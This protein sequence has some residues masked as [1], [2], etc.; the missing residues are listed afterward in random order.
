DGAPYSGGVLHAGTHTL[1]VTFTPTDNA[2][3][4]P[5]AST[6]MLVVDQA[7]QILTIAAV[8]KQV[9]GVAPFTVAVTGGASGRPVVVTPTPVSPCTA[10]SVS[11]GFVTITVTGAGTCVLTATQDGTADYSDAVPRQL[12]FVVD[13]RQASVTLAAIPTHTYGDAP[14]SVNA[15][16]TGSTAP[17][18]LTA[19][20][21]SVCNLSGTTV[22]LTGPGTCTVTADQA[23]DANYY[24][25]PTVKISFAVTCGV[26]VLTDLTKPVRSGAT[27]PIQLQLVGS[28]GGNLWSSSITVHAIGVDGSSVAP[29]P[30]NSQPGQDFR[31]VASPPGYQYNVKTTGLSAGTHILSYVVGTDPVVHTVTFTVTN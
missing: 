28:G 22:S 26:R 14:F 29:A 27:L 31:F 25:S 5:A 12:S 13:K 20:P 17:V 11:G 15:A 24:A 18:V 8:A 16:G 7:P 9:Y 4:A 30:G 23:G 19:G 10:S 2:D 21:S 6:V 1:A 3:Y